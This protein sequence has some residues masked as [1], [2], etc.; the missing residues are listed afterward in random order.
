MT[1]QVPTQNDIQFPVIWKCG[2]RNQCLRRHF[3]NQ[4]ISYKLRV[5]Q[6][7]LLCQGISP[8][9]GPDSLQHD[10]QHVRQA[11][12]LE[13]QHH[14]HAHLPVTHQHQPQANA[15]I[16]QAA[17][18]ALLRYLPVLAQ[19]YHQNQQV[20]Q[21]MIR[22]ATPNGLLTVDQLHSL[23]AHNVHHDY[24]I[25]N[26]IIN[27]SN[28][29]GHSFM[30]WPPSHLWHLN[31]NN[32]LQQATSSWLYMPL[33][34]HAMGQGHIF[35]LPFPLMPHEHVE[36]IQAAII[37]LQHIFSRHGISYHHMSGLL[38]GICHF[39]AHV[40]H[41]LLYMDPFVGMWA[42]TFASTLGQLT[43]GLALFLH[44]QTSLGTQAPSLTG[45]ER[46]ARC[47]AQARERADLD[48]QQCADRHRH[49]RA[50]MNDQQVQQRRNNNANR[51]REGRVH[52]TNMQQEQE[53][54]GDRI[55]VQNARANYPERRHF[56]QRGLRTFDQIKPEVVCF[57][58]RQR[59]KQCQGCC[60]QLWPHEV[61]A[62]GTGGSLC[63][64]DG[65]TWH[66]LHMVFP[67]PYPEPLRSYFT[68]A[69]L[70]GSLPKEF[71][72]NIRTYANA[73][74]MASP[75]VT[76]THPRQGI[77]MIQIQGTLYH[78]MGGIVPPP[79][80]Q[81][82]F[83]QIYILD[84]HQAQVDARI[85]ALEHAYDRHVPGHTHG[86]SLN[87]SILLALTEM[88]NRP[89]NQG[90]HPL[91]QDFR[92][93][94]HVFRT[95]RSVIAE[96]TMQHTLDGNVDPRTHNA[97]TGIGQH[98]IAGFF[99]GTGQGI[100]QGPRFKA[101]AASGLRNIPYFV[102]EW[103]SLRFVL[104]HPRNE[105]GWNW[106]L[107]LGPRGGGSFPSDVDPDNQEF[108][109]DDDDLLEATHGRAQHHPN[110]DLHAHDNSHDELDDAQR[111]DADTEIHR[112]R[113]AGGR[114]TPLQYAKFFLH[115]RPQN[116][117]CGYSLIHFGQEEFQEWI[118]TQWWR[119]EHNNLEWVARHQ[120]TIRGASLVDVQD[121]LERDD[122]PGDDDRIGRNIILPASYTG[123]PR[124][125]VKLY[126]DAMAI[127][128]KHGKPDI[129]ITMT[130]NPN[131]PEIRA[132]LLQGQIPNDR[133]DIVTRVFHAKLR[134]L[135]K[136]LVRGELFGRPQAYIYVI[137]WQKR[138]LPHVHILLILEDTY[139]LRGTQDIDRVVCAEIPTPG[140][141]L[142]DIV[143]RHMLHGPCGLAFP[144]SPCMTNDG[145]CTKHYP[146]SFQEYTEDPPDGYPL[147]RRR[148]SGHTFTNA[149]GFTFDN[150]WVVPYNPYLLLRFDCHINIETV[151]SVLSVK[152][153]FKYVYKGPDMSLM[154]MTV[155]TVDDEGRVI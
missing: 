112:T 96:G 134:Q 85:H 136:E 20:A 148:Q 31:H 24:N 89:P 123:S 72:D 25:S 60:A 44:Q 121:A 45:A 149:R 75:Q 155:N 101:V 23:A 129:F 92:T 105:Q 103:D 63:C 113:E 26:M 130:C 117:A 140:T 119:V 143:T 84:S 111:V 49:R 71:Q 61:H 78:R 133:P 21:A 108:E 47:R 29:Y 138:G 39:P 55:R 64:H 116:A 107:R 88:L 62:N 3:R 131:W 69:P 66:E 14:Q 73:F 16:V 99:P 57:S 76:Y 90:G 77:S 151:C 104:F 141:D 53:R 132:E 11:T 19:A 152:Y 10:N 5:I 97:P 12:S 87:R 100:Q 28:Y 145:N 93:I 128:R 50:N 48:R 56:F 41:A 7:L 46:M 91:I 67:Q 1:I 139:K 144:A 109:H 74:R 127:V 118:V 22:A 135:I 106:G 32:V 146:K 82:Q 122:M 18:Q 83:A 33:I 114:I 27:T 137:E 13:H 153:L 52:M 102:P 124:A 35:P 8:N 51:M 17:V 98:E 94:A 15:V 4:N 120:N 30:V 142:H 110:P 2:K 36:Q 34:L 70:P 126:Q 115:D 40:Q 9:P 68:N 86:L 6:L 65:R 37:L 80:L 58:L 38:D 81:P 59:N 95:Q 43:Y 79:G 54:V 42:S 154:R 147:Y 150:R 125:F